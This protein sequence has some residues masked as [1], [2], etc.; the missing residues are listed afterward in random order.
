VSK[1]A[2]EI[3]KELQA[4]FEPSDIE[5]RV[6]SGGLSNGKPWIMAI[7]YITARAVETRLDEVMGIDGWR[8]EY[9]DT[10]GGMK[11]GL[12]LLIDGKWITKWDGAPLNDQH[13]VKGVISDSIKR[14]AV[15]W[16]IGRYLYQ[17]DV[18]FA[19]CEPVD[20]RRDAYANY[21]KQVTK[22]HNGNN[23]PITTH[24]NWFTPQLPAWAVP[25]DDLSVFLDPMDSAESFGD[26]E[27]A[28]KIACMYGKSERSKDLIDQFVAYRDKNKKRIEDNRESIACKQLEEVKAFITTQIRSFNKLPSKV[29]LDS[30]YETSK[31]LLEVKC[32]DKLFNPELAF[33]LLEKGYSA[34]IEALT[35]KST[36]TIAKK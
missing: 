8:D 5:W 12:S 17:L 11:C 29:T 30:L 25:Q 14:A 18:V 9:V 10:Y 24:V 33:G 21:H 2:L 22:D 15:K 32:K 3:Q 7:P 13:P 35:K 26:L 4:M 31:E 20:S 36:K 1:S 23:K 28:F 27:E 34:R 16:G 19:E 6:Q